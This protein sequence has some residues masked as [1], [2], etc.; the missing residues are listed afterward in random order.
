M[1]G[2]DVHLAH[3][4]MGRH[5][6][7]AM[8]VPLGPVEPQ[9][10]IAP[11]RHQQALRVK[12]LAAATVGELVEAPV[13][14]L[15]MAIKRGVVDAEELGVVGASPVP[16]YDDAL[17]KRHVH[18]PGVHGKRHKRQLPLDLEPELGR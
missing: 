14:V 1:D 18:M 7:G 5:L 15:R 13:T 12:P 17:G 16:M 8:R 2:Q 9:Q 10:L 11:P 4:L 6:L 3:R